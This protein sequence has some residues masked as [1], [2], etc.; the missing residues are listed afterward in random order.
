LGFS[1]LGRGGGGVE[2]EEKRGREAA[3]LTLS[4][5]KSADKSVARGVLLGLGSH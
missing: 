4:A 1:F 3:G 2:R 5:R